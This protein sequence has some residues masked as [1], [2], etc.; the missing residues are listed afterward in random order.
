METLTLPQELVALLTTLLTGGVT[1]LVVAGFKGLGKAFN[2]DFS[3]SAKIVAGIVSTG[4]VGTLFGLVDAGLAAIPANY[5]PVVQGV[6]GLIVAY[7]SAVGIQYQS[8]K[9]ELQG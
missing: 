2:K 7:L 8:K 9:K 3:T 4:V 1:W 6:F 5:V